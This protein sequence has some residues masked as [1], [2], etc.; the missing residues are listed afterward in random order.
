M[1]NRNSPIAFEAANFSK[2]VLDDEED[3]KQLGQ[4]NRKTGNTCLA[5]HTLI[6]GRQENAFSVL[7]TQKGSLENT[8][9]VTS[10]QFRGRFLLG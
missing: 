7:H 9:Y 10:F 3:R 8:L 6:N 4:R 5:G 1:F 2:C